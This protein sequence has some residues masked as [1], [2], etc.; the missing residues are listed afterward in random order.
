M[1]RSRVFED[2]DFEV[3]YSKQSLLKLKDVREETCCMAR[4]RVFHIRGARFEKDSSSDN[5]E[6]RYG[7]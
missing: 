1:A 3:S 2:C 4:R 6:G 5:E 7:K